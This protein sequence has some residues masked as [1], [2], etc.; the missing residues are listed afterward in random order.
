MSARRL[1]NITARTVQ[2]A[3]TCGHARRDAVLSVLDLPQRAGRVPATSLVD[4]TARVPAHSWPLV[5]SSLLCLA[6]ASSEHK[7]SQTHTSPVEPQHQ[8]I[9]GE[10]VVANAMPASLQRMY[11]D[12]G[13]V[14]ALDHHD[15][16]HPQL[17]GLAGLD[18]PEWCK[19]RTDVPTDYHMLPA[20][21]KRRRRLY[22]QRNADRH[23]YIGT[24]ASVEHEIHAS[25][26]QVGDRGVVLFADHNALISGWHKI[27]RM[28]AMALAC[29]SLAHV[30]APLPAPNA[31]MPDL[32]NYQSLRTAAT[33]LFGV[34]ARRYIP[35]P[36]DTTFECQPQPEPEL[37][38]N[39]NT[40]MHNDM[41]QHL[42]S[43]YKPALSSSSPPPSPPPSAAPKFNRLFDAYP[44][45]ESPMSIL[46]VAEQD[47]PN[48]TRA[49]PQLQCIISSG[50]DKLLQSYRYLLHDKR[51]DP[52]KIVFGGEGLG[53]GLVIAAL[54]QIK[55]QQAQQVW[56]PSSALP[57]PAGAFLLSPW[58]GAQASDTLHDLA[59]L[60]HKYWPVRPMH[61]KVEQ[62][63]YPE[64]QAIDLTQLGMCYNMQADSLAGLP[65]LYLQFGQ[66]DCNKLQVEHFIQDCR[67]SGVTL[68][69]D[70]FV[71]MPRNFHSL[72]SIAPDMYIPYQQLGSWIRYTT[73]VSNTDPF[74]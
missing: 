55:H 70:E 4:A 9:D 2:Q 13:L 59:T 33:K 44:T 7:Q 46:P 15:Q 5:A 8:C 68:Q 54:L 3:K 36:T 74:R 62:F 10:W 53:A 45:H 24:A 31:A 14:T 66:H 22:H 21:Q 61:A 72:W 32:P 6:P 12:G 58:F 71:A 57:M 63:L 69:A 60:R 64:E 17:G 38:I 19:V 52:C 11:A 1:L 30:F 65:K 35:F 16:Q 18:A 43:S 47:L 73:Q 28:P 20:M 27:H 29:A 49:P 40:C 67:R 41:M 50:I 37:L 34:L 39:S 26:T 25:S 51:I 48:Y 56:P 23:E 42:K